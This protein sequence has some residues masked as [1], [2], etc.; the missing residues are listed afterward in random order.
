MA[1]SKKGKGEPLKA[2]TRIK[3]IIS[4]VAVWSLLIVFCGGAMCGKHRKVD[5]K[6]AEAS[7]SHYQLALNFY[8]QGN[9]IEA[10]KTLE[11]AE[12][13]NPNNQDA[14]YLY[15][16]I[17]LGKKIYD[18]SEAAFKRAIE[19]DP[20]FSDAYN[21][22]GAVYIDQK[23]W[24]KAIDIL[25][26]PSSDILYPYRDKVYDNLGW[27]HHKLGE[28]EKA[29]DYL[30]QACHE[31]PK[32]CH[33]WY[34]L[35]RVHRDAGK[36]AEAV[37]AFA[38]STSADKTCT[39]FLEGQ[40]ELAMAAIKAGDHDTARPALMKCM[41]LAKDTERGAT[42]KRYLETLPEKHNDIIVK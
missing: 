9:T 37:R 30:I 34:N 10:L 18:K 41:T 4:M 39:N 1:Q 14:Q 5:E 15:G 38:K 35:G 32:N 36:F 29:A 19:I 11:Q 13:L 6:D 42:C 25:Q 22:L 21:G 33:A 27:C 40:Y 26:K 20:D 28:S 8:Q 24:Q 23:Q 3:K 16:I 31:N 17:Y 7:D 2:S 12:E